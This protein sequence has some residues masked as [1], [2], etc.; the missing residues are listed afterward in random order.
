MTTFEGAA[1]EN[2]YRQLALLIL[3]G[4]VAI[5]WVVKVV[6]WPIRSLLLNS[7]AISGLPEYYQHLGVGDDQM[8]PAP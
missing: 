1:P 2:D 4:P 7:F 3:L 8:C 6:H 5:R